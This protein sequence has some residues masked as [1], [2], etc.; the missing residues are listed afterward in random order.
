MDELI[1]T[2][3]NNLKLS[4]QTGRK[5]EHRPMRLVIVIRLQHCMYHR[6]PR[7]SMT[8]LIPLISGRTI[9]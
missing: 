8:R 7:F 6:Y 1:D 3:F 9:L 4:L 5:R 2:C